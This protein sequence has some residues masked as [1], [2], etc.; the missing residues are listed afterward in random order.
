MSGQLSLFVA[1]SR[2]HLVREVREG[3]VRLP[4][5]D[6]SALWRRLRLPAGGLCDDLTSEDLRALR[7]VLRGG[8]R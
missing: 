6:R 5:R 4:Q 3:L 1:S 8:G 2:A 7:T